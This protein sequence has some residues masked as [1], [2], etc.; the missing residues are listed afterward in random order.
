[1]IMLMISYIHAFTYS[2]PKKQT[3]KH[4]TIRK[5]KII[6]RWLQQD[7]APA[8]EETAPAV[9]ETAPAVEETAPAVEETAPAVEETAPA[10]QE[11]A[12]VEATVEAGE[13]HHLRITVVFCQWMWMVS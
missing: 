12:P 9:E 3:K 7:P 13:A 1:M 2:I 4:S 10:V 8:V 11:T 5:A 6:T